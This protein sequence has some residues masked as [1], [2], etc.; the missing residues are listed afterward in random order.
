MKRD[1][2]LCRAILLRAGESDSVIVDFSAEEFP[3]YSLEQFK[4]HIHLLEDA[5]LIYPGI[6]VFGPSCNIRLTWEG[7]DFLELAKDDRKWKQVLDD[8][9]KKGVP[10]TLDLLKAALSETFSNPTA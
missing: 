9:V 8:L 5:G 6:Q 7:N 10:L 3:K 2:N 1:M 4:E